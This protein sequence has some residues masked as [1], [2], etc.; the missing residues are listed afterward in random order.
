M[1]LE[2]HTLE[3]SVLDYDLLSGDRVIHK[4]FS[5]PPLGRIRWLRL[6]GHS[7][8]HAFL[9]FLALGHTSG[10]LFLLLF[11]FFLPFVE[12][13]LCM[14]HVT[15]LNVIAQGGMRVLGIGRYLRIV[16]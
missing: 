13:I 14:L 16:C 3:S 10:T 1:G 6:A 12:R 11:C 4:P 15:I 2:K 5:S 9:L 8:H 7:I